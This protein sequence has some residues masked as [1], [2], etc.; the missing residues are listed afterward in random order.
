MFFMMANITS[1]QSSANKTEPPKAQVKKEV[2]GNKIILSFH[3]IIG[4][5][6][7]DIQTF[8]DKLNQAGFSGLIKATID[9]KS[10]EMTAVFTKDATEENILSF[11]WAV[12]YN[13]YHFI[14]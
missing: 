1:A 14:R 2:V 10:K 4:E 3:N 13:S 12:G 7:A 5:T 6:K 11:F 8:E 9:P